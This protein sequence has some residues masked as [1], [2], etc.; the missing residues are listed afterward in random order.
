L[1]RA[2]VTVKLEG[3]DR[4]FD[5]EVPAELPSRELADLITY[6]LRPGRGVGEEFSIRCAKPEV[7]RGELEPGQSLAAA[8]LW[9]GTYLVIEPAS[10]A[11]Q[12][13]WSVIVKEWVQDISKTD[14]DSVSVANPTPEPVVVRPQPPAAVTP[15]RPP[16]L[17]S[18]SPPPGSPPPAVNQP[19]QPP[20]IA[21]WVPLSADESPDQPPVKPTPDMPPESEEDDRKKSDDGFAWKR[22]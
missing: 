14:A 1:Q 3:E 15:V 16:P 9:D 12:Q 11:A 22:L 2:I 18:A 17:P 4:E 21:T 8:G 20:S 7:L 5:L 19:N 6:N 13:M 10:G